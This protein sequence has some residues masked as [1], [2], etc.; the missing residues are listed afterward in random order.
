MSLFDFAML[1]VSGEPTTPGDPP[2]AAPSG[3]VATAYGGPPSKA[4]V[5]WVN[6]DA[7]AYTRVYKGTVTPANLQT[8]ALPG[9]TVIFTDILWDPPGTIRLTHYKEG[10]ESSADAVPYGMT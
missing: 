6:G 2:A 4:R 7:A 10:V 9:V 1:L 8:Y 5:D 3:G